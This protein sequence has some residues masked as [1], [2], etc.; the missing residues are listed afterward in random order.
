[1]VASTEPKRKGR[2]PKKVQYQVF[3]VL[4]G[5]TLDDYWKQLLLSCSMGKFPR[6]VT[7][8]DD[9]LIHRRGR[10]CSSI[11]LGNNHDQTTDFK[12]VIDFFRSLGWSSLQD[13]EAARRI[14]DDKQ[15]SL[16]AQM[17]SC[18]KDIKRPQIKELLLGDFVQMLS[19]TLNLTTREYEYLQAQV[20]I[21]QLFKAINAQTVV[22]ANGKISEITGL[23]VE[24]EERGKRK[25]SFHRN[26]SLVSATVSPG[27]LVRE[28]VENLDQTKNLQ[29]DWLAYCD[30]LRRINN[31]CLSLARL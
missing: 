17:Y 20:A 18:W 10:V 3:Q 30:N 12:R 15:R 8:K 22:M 19:E 4:S 26:S 7:Y 23:Q 31:F 24:G 25:F 16:Q 9:L 1:M 27:P 29:N 13:N 11:P 5:Y 14:V 6:Y 21:A 2:P 28:E